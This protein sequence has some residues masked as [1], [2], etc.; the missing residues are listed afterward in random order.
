MLSLRGPV[1]GAPEKPTP[2]PKPM[3]HPG[4]VGRPERAA[5]GPPTAHSPLPVAGLGEA[6][7]CPVVTLWS[8]SASS[9]SGIQRPL[10]SADHVGGWGVLSCK[11]NVLA[12]GRPCHRAAEAVPARG[13]LCGQTVR[14]PTARVPCPRPDSSMS[15]SEEIF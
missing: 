10:G 11:M 7:P 15:S 2:S 12:Q 14:A 4:Q 8:L 13:M 1:P 9:G 3:L 6:G 5:A